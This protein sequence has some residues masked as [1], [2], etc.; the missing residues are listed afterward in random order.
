M[1]KLHKKAKKIIIRAEQDNWLEFIGFKEHFSLSIHNHNQLLSSKKEN[2]N[3]IL[4]ST[5][6]TN[7]K[8]T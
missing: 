5:I 4:I 7:I 2:Y 1:P 8:Q 3:K 6:Q